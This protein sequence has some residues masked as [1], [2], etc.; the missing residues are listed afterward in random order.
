M[1]KLLVTSNFS[2]SHNVLCSY[3]SLVR[4]NVVLG[5]N[6]LKVFSFVPHNPLSNL[7][8]Y[9][10][11]Q[12]HKWQLCSMGVL[13]TNLE[14]RMHKSTQGHK[15][16]PTYIHKSF[17]LNENFKWLFYSLRRII[18]PNHFEIPS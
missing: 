4:Q 2:F 3:I 8:T 16:A 17:C 12:L 11:L 7:H 18:V 9:W 5:G 13:L 15:H 6:G 1:E 10:T 14:R